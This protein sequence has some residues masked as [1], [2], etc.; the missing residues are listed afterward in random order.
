MKEGYGE[1][2]WSNGQSYA[3]NW[4]ANKMHGTGKLTLPDGQS[5]KVEYKD[6]VWVKWLE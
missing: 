4:K 5:S 2:I 6:G 3:G 1:L